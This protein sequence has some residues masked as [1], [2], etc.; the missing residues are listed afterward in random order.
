[1]FFYSPKRHALANASFPYRHY[2]LDDGA[3]PGTGLG[4]HFSD[5]EFRAA[6][7]FDA[8]QGT[9]SDAKLV[10]GWNGDAAGRMNRYG[11]LRLVVCKI[12]WG[13]GSD[14]VEV[15]LPFEDM[16]L[17]AVPSSTRPFPLAASSSRVSVASS[18]R[19]GC[20]SL[21]SSR[22]STWRKADV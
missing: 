19:R 2:I 9:S 16:Q 14:T 10:G 22:S 1:M 11:D 5:K 13:A 6:Q 21:L 4:I 18:A 20:R 7:Y 17:P 15:Y 12:T 8:S 3:E